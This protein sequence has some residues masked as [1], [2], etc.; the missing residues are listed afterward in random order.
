MKL[1][2]VLTAV[3]I[4]SGLLLLS[5]CSKQEQEYEQRALESPSNEWILRH[6]KIFTFERMIHEYPEQVLDNTGDSGVDQLLKAGVLAKE[7]D[8]YKVETSTNKWNTSEDLSSDTHINNIDFTLN[9]I[10]NNNNVTWCGDSISGKDFV[11]N[12]TDLHEGFSASYEEYEKSIA[13]YV[14]CG[15]GEL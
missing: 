13:D 6:T 2:K 12:Y 3:L 9:V 5:S 14:D 10:L 11:R 7:G 4:F 15:T 8:I 1:K